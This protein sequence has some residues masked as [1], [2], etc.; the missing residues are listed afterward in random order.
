MVSLGMVALSDTHQEMTPSQQRIASFVMDRL[1]L[2]ENRHTLFKFKQ[3]F[4]PRWE[5]RY[6]VTNTTLA[7]PKVALAIL[8]L[9]N[10]PR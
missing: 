10:Y 5:S 4:H 2:L 6:I 3:K 9:R 1:H 8:R 7:L